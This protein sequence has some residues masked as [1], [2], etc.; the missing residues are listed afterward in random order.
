[1]SGIIRLDL[2]SIVLGV[3]RTTTRHIIEAGHL[4][5]PDPIDRRIH[6][7]QTDLW[8]Y[9]LKDLGATAC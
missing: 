3:R 7:H 9:D 5:D 4:A 2:D 8:V 6:N 1:M